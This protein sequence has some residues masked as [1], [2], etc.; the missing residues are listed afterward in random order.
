MTL[1][2]T[3]LVFTNLGTI[4]INWTETAK[5]VLARSQAGPVTLGLSRADAFELMCLLDQSA[6]DS[7]H[8]ASVAT[9]VAVRDYLVQRAD[10][11]TDL[12][13]RINGALS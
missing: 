3:G 5:R 6:E 12:Y 10:V 13:D 7:R 1:L 11:A 4:L 8:R 2:I 9:P